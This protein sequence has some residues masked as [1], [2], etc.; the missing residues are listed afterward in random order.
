MEVTAD[1]FGKKKKKA[2]FNPQ[3][4]LDTNFASFLREYKPDHTKVL[5]IACNE[6][7]SIHHG[8]KNDIDRHTKSQ[9]H[10]NKMKSFN[11]NRHL[12]YA[13]TFVISK[14]FVHGYY[15]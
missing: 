9:K 2:V 11:I 7:I 15:L 10:V 12:T 13:Q 8:G 3:W 1:N 4:L 14:R 5:C 6:Q